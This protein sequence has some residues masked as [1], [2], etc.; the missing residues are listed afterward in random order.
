MVEST[1]GLAGCAALQQTIKA[2]IE[3]VYVHCRTGECL[4]Q[5][6]RQSST[7]EMKPVVVLVTN[8]TSRSAIFCMVSTDSSVGCT[9]FNQ[10]TGDHM[11]LFKP[12]H[13]KRLILTSEPG[14]PSIN[15]TFFSLPLSSLQGP[16]IGAFFLVH[17]SM[18]G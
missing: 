3:T 9:C 1:P 14:T 18:G 10:F 11:M 4:E 5:G 7:M 13:K 12:R 6:L 15:H 2:H 8:Q 16:K 17:L